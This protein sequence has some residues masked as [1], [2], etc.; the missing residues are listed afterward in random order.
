MEVIMKGLDDIRR[1]G[2]RPEVVGCFLC[3][4]KLLFL[5]KKEHN[6]WQLPQGGIKNQ[7]TPGQALVREMTE[8]LEDAFI[9]KCSETA[10]YFYSDKIDFKISNENSRQLFN[11][12][13]VEI[14]MRGKHYLFYYILSDQAVIKINETEFDD[15][16]WCDLKKCSEIINNIYQIGKKRIYQEVI[17][18][19]SIL[20]LLK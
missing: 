8:E 3:N 19:L 6:L 11:D 7:E 12:N 9:S 4:E 16:D 14:G 5:Y 18:Q 13:G 2:Y 1:S 15:Y 17:K 10:V 20:G